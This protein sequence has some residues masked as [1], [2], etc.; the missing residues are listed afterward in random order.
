[1]QVIISIVVKS[2][3]DSNQTISH[4]EAKTLALHIRIALQ[5]YGVLFNTDKFLPYLFHPY[6]S[7]PQL[8]PRPCWSRLAPLRLLL[9]S[10]KK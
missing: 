7:F 2:D 10:M 6:L 9:Y 4:K 1:M 8:L 3:K 5:E